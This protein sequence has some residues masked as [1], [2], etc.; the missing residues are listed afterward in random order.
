MERST[1]VVGTS[2]TPTPC[3]AST[4]PGAPGIT[5]GLLAPCTTTSAHWSSSRPFI[6][7]TSA[8][9]TLTIRLG[10]TSRSWA[11]WLPRASASTSTRL[12]PTTSVSAFKSVVVAT[13][14]SL[15]AARAS[16]VSRPRAMSTNST[17]RSVR[18]N[19]GISSE[20]MGGVSAQDERRLE[21]DLVLDPRA[22]DARER[23]AAGRV[24]LRVLV[25]D[26]EAQE[27]RG[28]K[29][30]IWLDG[31]LMAGRRRVLRVVVLDAGR[32]AAEPTGAEWLDLAEEI[33]P[34][35]IE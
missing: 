2:S 16:V 23:T 7:S 18:G 26:P 1:R 15:S 9:R 34:D 20:R 13:T 3:D 19:I 30:Q 29:R 24:A 14:R 6:T 10:R 8:R 22:P 32:E 31:P 4:R 12:P 21:E 11:F 17:M 25:P 5:L 28:P 27:L 35:A 33:P